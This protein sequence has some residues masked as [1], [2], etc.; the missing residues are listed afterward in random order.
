MSGSVEINV[1]T[2]DFTRL[3]A[4]LARID[5]ADLDKILRATVNEVAITKVDRLIQQKVAA[6][7]GVMPHQIE[8]RIQHNRSDSRP[9]VVRS[10][11]MW[12]GKY[13]LSGTRLAESLGAN[14][15]LGQV[16]VGK[17]IWRRGFWM[18]NGRNGNSALMQRLTDERYPIKAT[19]ADTDMIV[20]E[21]IDSITPSIPPLLEAVL[22]RRIAAYLAKI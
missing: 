15:T 16:Q 21:V 6:E 22:D 10:A 7:L 19:M 1:D 3:Q 13:R 2:R 4:T 18:E 12:Y 5:P 17:F 20:Q 14:F 8:S 9:H 11:W